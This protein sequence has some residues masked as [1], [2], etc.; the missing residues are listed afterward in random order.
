MSLLLLFQLVE[1]APVPSPDVSLHDLLCTA[2][3]TQQDYLN[4]ITEFNLLI[5]IQDELSDDIFDYLDQDTDDGI[6]TAEDRDFWLDCIFS[7][8][9]FTGERLPWGSSAPITLDE[10]DPLGL[11]A[12]DDNVIIID[13]DAIDDENPLS[14]SGVVRV[15]FSGG[16]TNPCTLLDGTPKNPAALFSDGAKTLYRYR[17]WENLLCLNETGG[18][19]S[20]RFPSNG[21]RVI[22]Y[23]RKSS[24]DHILNREIL[25]RKPT[26]HTEL[27]RITVRGYPGEFPLIYAGQSLDDDISPTTVGSESAMIALGN[28]GLTR[29]NFFFTK[30]DWKGYR[31]RVGGG[32]R[33]YANRIIYYTSS[34]SGGI[35]HS[36]FTET[37]FIRNDDPLALSYPNLVDSVW[38]LRASGAAQL[39]AG[40]LISSTNFIWKQNYVEPVA[41]A[42]WPADMTVP[43][44]GSLISNYETFA[45]PWLDFQGAENVVI[46]QSKFSGFKA[47]TMVRI[48]SCQNVIIRHCDGEV[49][50]KKVYD[51]FDS[52]N[53]LIELNRAKK[54]VDARYQL[55]GGGGGYWIQYSRNV[56]LQDNIVWNSEPIYSLSNGIGLQSSI[57]AL[58]NVIIRRNISYL[59]SL[60]ADSGASDFEIEADIYNNLIVNIP[61]EQQIR[62]PPDLPF[63]A[64]IKID[65]RGITGTPGLG[66]I[67]IHEN[68]IV[69]AEAGE[70]NL[71]IRASG[72]TLKYTTGDTLTGWTSNISL[73]PKWAGDPSTGDFTLL[74]DSPYINYFLPE[75]PFIATP[76]WDYNPLIDFCFIAPT[77]TVEIQYPSIYAA[78]FGHFDIEI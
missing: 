24:S 46:L 58:T 28:S 74:A 39:S 70:A 21:G 29:H 50:D 62:S 1:T 6:L 48:L 33:V 75:M 56:I 72:G 31:N 38:T 68:G 23:I 7:R 49:Y 22:I 3:T 34:A 52:D 35:T 47:N 30:L 63:N 65:L 25:L 66:S 78:M 9:G 10:A 54:G 44:S 4:F 2:R 13:P 40:V 73:D 76:A 59:G 64:N 67:T 69:R 17:L 32:G 77:P 14:T 12:L 60:G 55:E 53:V 16:S 27:D 43:Y 61:I 20:A 42:N 71:A 41:A 8:E 37:Q 15:T 57:A 36:R 26:T 51:I 45:G 19:S 11:S 18:S 5:S